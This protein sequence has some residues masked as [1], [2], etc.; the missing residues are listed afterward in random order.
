MEPNNFKPDEDLKSRLGEGV[1]TNLLSANN[2]MSRRVFVSRIGKIVALGALAHFTLLTGKAFATDTGDA[3]PGGLPADDICN[4]PA[5]PDKCPGQLPPAD[6]CPPDGNTDE[7][8]CSTGGSAADICNEPA[9]ATSDQCESGLPADDICDAN[10]PRD[11]CPT[12]EAKTGNIEDYCPPNYGVDAGD[13]CLGGGDSTNGA[14]QDI[15]K[16]IGSGP[17]G[18]D[19]CTKGSTGGGDDCTE[20]SPDV[21][22][23]VND[24]VCY[25]GTNT[26]SGDGGSD[27]C[28]PDPNDFPGRSTGSDQ[29]N[30][31]TPAQDICN[32]AGQIP[33]DG[34]WD[35]C[36]GGSVAVD[37]CEPTP[38]VNSEDYCVGGLP[39]NDECSTPTDKDECPGGLPN[40]DSCP[41]GEPPEDECTA[42]GGCAGGDQV[43]TEPL[44]DNCV[45]PV[46]ACVIPYPDFPNPE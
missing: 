46:D 37:T 3:C 1:L 38:P 34:L 2:P 27:W 32:G 25:D 39:D 23:W 41:N 9:N 7:D 36:P 18:G 42:F 13:V 30:D 10:N 6:Y 28:D 15:C 43:G 35:S 20:Q 22:T 12:G 24:D 40:E 4:P 45:P 44:V 14:V 29:C 17:S 8:I 5:D 31:G 21:C 26:P 19:E 16:P 33:A 11:N